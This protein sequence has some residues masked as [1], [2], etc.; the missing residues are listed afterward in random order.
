VTLTR[1]DNQRRRGQAQT[2][3]TSARASAGPATGENFCSRSRRAFC[4]APPPGR[5]PAAKRGPD[6]PGERAQR[7]KA[8]LDPRKETP[9]STRLRH[10][11]AHMRGV[12]RQLRRSCLLAQTS[13]TG[14]WWTRD[15]TFFWVVA[16]G[17]IDP[18]LA[19]VAIVSAKRLRVWVSPGHRRQCRRGWMRRCACRAA[20]WLGGMAS[21]W[22]ISSSAWCG[23][24]LPS[25]NEPVAAPPASLGCASCW[26]STGLVHRVGV[27]RVLVVE[28]AAPVFP[29]LVWH[30]VRS[31]MPFSSG[32]AGVRPATST[33]LSGDASSVFHHPFS[34]LD[35]AVPPL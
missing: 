24:S 5:P 19:M 18:W 28:G 1:G 10:H 9:H 21:R 16:L 31:E 2:P 7:P 11:D 27:G 32:A 25:W 4:C 17:E 6:R 14:R 15:G 13:A 20:L 29:A 22:S 8:A 12:W 23:M 3:T 34:R 30:E 35:P 26:P 33:P